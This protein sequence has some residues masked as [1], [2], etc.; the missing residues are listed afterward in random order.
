VDRFLRGVAREK[1]RAEM[2]QTVARLAV[3]IVTL[4]LALFIVFGLPGDQRARPR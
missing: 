1:L 3:N 4:L 2:L